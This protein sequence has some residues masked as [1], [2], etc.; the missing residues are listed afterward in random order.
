MAE[1]IIAGAGNGGLAAAIKLS[2][3][4]YSVIL[5][6]K[7]ERDALGLPQKDIFEQD[8]FDYAGLPLPENVQYIKNFLTFIP[9]E[10]ETEKIILP[11]PSRNAIA[12]DRKDLVNHLLT[13]AEESGVR[14]IF[15]CP[16]LSPI[17]LGNRVAGVKTA[18]GDFYGDLV[19]DS[20]GIDS[21][22]REKLPE[23]MGV[24]RDVKKYDCVYTYRAYFE[25]DFNAPQPETPYNLII[26]ED[27][28]VGFSWVVTEE[29]SVDVLI[30]RFEPLD[31]TAVLSEL[32]KICSE[33]P[34]ISKNFIR[35][36]LFS[37]IPV[38][39]PLGVLV[40]DGYAAVGDSAF[41]TYAVKG[42]GITYAVKAGSILA[43]AVIQDKSGFFTAETLWEYNR[44]FFKEIGFTAGR[45]AVLRN[46]LNY[47][48]A[49]EV[50]DVFKAGIL[51]TADFEMIST[52]RLD[53]LFGAP[54]RAFLKEKIKMVRENAILKE[55]LSNLIIWMGRL[56]VTE[57]HFPNKYDRKDV[58]K[59]N[60]KYNEFFNSI[61][62]ID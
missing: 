32:Q 44:R 24:K 58:E 57:T 38:S 27:G 10:A 37:K 1:I 49:K 29:N 52:E 16:V 23:Y 35:G 31:N 54:G 33:N 56:V 13:L 9:L 11:P 48:T 6:E 43:D 26:K 40:A 50:N 59:W 14:L 36:G 62:K 4:G 60:E 25:R 17:I 41:M 28:T 15:G 42:S 30:C 21:P 12:M 55:K 22:L 34:H 2:K 7:C 45:L 39:N 8:T 5:L 51:T 61:R 47:I 18:A 53:M 19:I 3:A 20:C 46:L